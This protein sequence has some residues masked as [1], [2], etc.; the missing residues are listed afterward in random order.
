MIFFR[1]PEIFLSFC[2]L[3]KLSSEPFAR[4]RGRFKKESVPV[5]SECA[6]DVYAQR[7]WMHALK[8]AGEDRLNICMCDW[9][10]DTIFWKFMKRKCDLPV[11][12]FP[13]NGSEKCMDYLASERTHCGQIGNVVIQNEIGSLSLGIVHHCINRR[14]D[15][16]HTNAQTKNC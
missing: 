8:W 10:F 12:L 5:D 4:P 1:L 16:E 3:N 9:V 13:I 2:F 6:F 14:H 11:V 7:L 15:I